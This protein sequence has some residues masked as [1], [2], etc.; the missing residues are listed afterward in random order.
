MTRTRV[1]SAGVEQSYLRDL[2]RAFGGALLFALPLLM[3]M[4]MWER[5]AELE[6][7]RL[8][9]FLLAGLPL[10]FGLAHYAGFSNRRGLVN[11]LLDVAGALFVAAVTAG[12]L[13]ALLGA[14]EFGNP[15]AIAGQL[16]LQLVPAAMGALIARKQLAGSQDDEDVRQGDY[17]GE[18]FLMM[19]G[20]L[21]LGLNLAPTEEMQL[22]A[23]RVGPVAALG[24]M[25]L[26]IT[27][28]HLIVFEVGFAGQEEKESPLGAFLH[29]SVPGYALCLLSSAGVLGLFG[30]NDGHGLAA[31][32]GNTVVLG[33]PAAL[34]AAA[35]RLL[36]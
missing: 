33:F 6:P 12:G 22:I 14:L 3:T 32:V 2:G 19:A 10:L 26:S 7:W 35:A 21:Y 36:V 1:P 17:A 34:G 25:A 18:L 4:E 5:G 16:T 9:V 15:R 24:V 30:A 11:N 8:L 20:A 13:L 27:L 23:Y 31:I 28:L 29:F